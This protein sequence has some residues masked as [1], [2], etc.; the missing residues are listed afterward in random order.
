MPR[1]GEEARQRLQQAAL[2]LYREQGY[3]NT[4]TSEIA[5]RAG[6]TERTFFR[7]FIDK[8]EVLFDGET[9]LRDALDTAVLAAP[10]DLEPLATLLHAFS[11]VVPILEHNRSVSEP[12]HEVISSTP[13]LRER[14]LAKEASLARAVARALQRRGVQTRRASLAAQ[15][16]MAAFSQATLA[17]LDEPQHDLASLLT[18][19]F[20]DLHVLAAPSKVAARSSS[21]KPRRSAAAFG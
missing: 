3:A 12:R 19:A 15:I 14:E 16:G 6:V 7:H 13:A 17:W 18:Q 2:D 9:M 11:S 8:R 20:D 4:T 10:D 21:S 1:S 5:A